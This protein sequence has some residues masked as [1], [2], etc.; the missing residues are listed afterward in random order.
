[1]GAPVM[2]LHVSQPKRSVSGSGSDSD[3][4]VCVC[5]CARL[6]VC[7]WAWA[8]LHKVRQ[9]KVPKVDGPDVPIVV[10]LRT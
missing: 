8:S 2:Q 4:G 6:C 1:V 10:E 9:G 5:V 3:S 7:V